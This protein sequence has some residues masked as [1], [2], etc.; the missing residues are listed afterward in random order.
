MFKFNFKIFSR[1]VHLEKYQRILKRS[2]PIKNQQRADF[3]SK[4]QQLPEK[5][6]LLATSLISNM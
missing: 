6:V 1:K 4:I 3:I 2:P 5:E